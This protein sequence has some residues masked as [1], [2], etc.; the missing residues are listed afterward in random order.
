[1][2]TTGLLICVCFDR[3]RELALVLRQVVVLCI[4]FFICR[5]QNQARRRSFA[6]F[7]LQNPVNLVSILFLTS[8]AGRI[9]S[10]GAIQGW[11]GTRQLKLVLPAAVLDLTRQLIMLSR[12]LLLLEILCVAFV[13]VR[14]G[15]P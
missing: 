15:S 1:M 9:P 3:S 4:D 8:E 13:E 6:A 12:P 5:R 2:V 14:G 11:F 10:C 7:F